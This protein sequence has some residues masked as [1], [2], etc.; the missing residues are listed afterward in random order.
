[1]IEALLRALVGAAADSESVRAAVVP[2]LPPELELTPRVLRRAR[3]RVEMA[4][5]FRLAGSDAPRA[6][7]PHLCAALKLDARWLANRGVLSYLVR[8][9]SQ[10]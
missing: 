1:L 8:Q 9:R 3:A 4:Q 10:H 6:A 7:H 5:F 2:N